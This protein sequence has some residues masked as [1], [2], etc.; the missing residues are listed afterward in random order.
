MSINYNVGMSVF[1]PYQVVKSFIA[2]ELDQAEGAKRFGEIIDI[3]ETVTT[4]IVDFTGLMFCQNLGDYEIR[5][6]TVDAEEDEY[7]YMEGFIEIPAGQGQLFWL[8][9]TSMK[10]QSSGDT[11]MDYEIISLV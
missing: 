6:N 2:N 5:I 3:S 8:G 1:T 11:Q 9:T 10:I 4:L 7:G